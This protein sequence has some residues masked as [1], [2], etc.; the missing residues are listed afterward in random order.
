MEIVIP[1]E[2]LEQARNQALERLRREGGPL[3][4]YAKVLVAR[5]VF[6]DASLQSRPRL[7]LRLDNDTIKGP[8]YSVETRNVQYVFTFS[9]AV[10]GVPFSDMTNDEEEAI[11]DWMWRIG[12]RPRGRRGR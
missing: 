1:C 11:R 2:S 6:G 4:A 5:N 7:H 9:N 8:C 3:P 10:G 12:A